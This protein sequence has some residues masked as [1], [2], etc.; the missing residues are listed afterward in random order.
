MLYP[1]PAYPPLHEAPASGQ[2]SAILAPPAGH[3]RAPHRRAVSILA[4]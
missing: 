2:E 1:M 4:E 3:T